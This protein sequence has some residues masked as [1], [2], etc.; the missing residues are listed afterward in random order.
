MNTRTIKAIKN[1]VFVMNENNKTELIEWSYFNKDLLLPHAITATAAA[2]KILEGTLNKAVNKLVSGPRG[3]Y[4]QLAD[5]I[6]EGK[7]D[8]LVFF[9]NASETQLHRNEFEA[10][11]ESARENNIIV[12]LNKSTAD[13]VFTSLLMEKNYP[14]EIPG[15]DDEKKEL[16]KPEQERLKKSTVVEAA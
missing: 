5:M 6:L 4:R 14:I 15:L 13:F 3:E 7:I 8:V 1:I 10:L 9:G 16:S 11:L 2:G 12:A